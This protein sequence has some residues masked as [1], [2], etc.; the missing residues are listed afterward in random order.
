[1][2][3]DAASFYRVRSATPYD[4]ALLARYLLARPQRSARLCLTGTFA[5]R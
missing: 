4:D 5:R 3:G 1:M 2:R